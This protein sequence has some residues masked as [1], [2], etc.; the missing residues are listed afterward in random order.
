MI[1]RRFCGVSG[2][3]REPLEAML[4]VQKNDEDAGPEL[5]DCNDRYV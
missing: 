5:V 4:A 1:G 3:I 2:A